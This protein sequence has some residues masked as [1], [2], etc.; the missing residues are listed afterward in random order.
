MLVNLDFIFFASSFSVGVISTLLMYLH[1]RKYQHPGLLI[2]TLAAFF[3]NFA[4]FIYFGHFLFVGV[5][6]ELAMS[7]LG[8]IM[9]MLSFTGGYLYVIGTKYLAEITR[10][11]EYLFILPIYLIAIIT[12]AVGGSHRYIDQEW[13]ITYSPLYTLAI[14]GVL[15]FI[16]QIE[17]TRSFYNMI[18]NS[19]INTLK[20]IFYG[21]TI[22]YFFI[23]PV[24]SLR[25]IV[26][27]PQSSI[28]IPISFFYLM[29]T[30]LVRRYPLIFFSTMVSPNF[31]LILNRDTR[32]ILRAYTFSNLDDQFAY[33]DK[34]SS[35]L[36][37]IEKIER[38]TFYFETS[39][40]ILEFDDYTMFLHTSE[41]FQ[42]VMVTDD[43]STSFTY[44]IKELSKMLPNYLF[45]DEVE[46]D[47]PE[48]NDN[49]SQLIN[50]TF[51]HIMRR[52]RVEQRI[53]PPKQ[54]YEVLQH[55]RSNSQF[56]A[57]LHPLR[58]SIIRILF[59]S[60][61][62]QRSQLVKML[63]INS[64]SL[65]KQ[66]TAMSELN[67]VVSTQRFV[68]NKP[69]TIIE[70]TPYGLKQYNDFRNYLNSILM[71]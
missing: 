17:I 4:P 18:R 29:I 25:E 67:L 45:G 71:G 9:A 49:I 1:F 8:N 54:I 51:T 19:E 21:T 14:F 15:S 50:S 55:I 30:L 42:V 69:R 46:V 53:I 33:E 5:E 66:I 40:N 48:S 70:L 32:K 57:L 38:E 6:Y 31:L 63:S 35:S 10:P 64:G 59:E 7:G 11:M 68:E 20:H 22:L 56:N 60:N 16:L 34:L 43:R 47:F 12:R 13:V 44:L 28:L 24:L 23:V 37:I 39:L 3:S 2:L 41:D 62:L 52:L 58:F 61:Y 26:S 36:A 65:Q 27:I